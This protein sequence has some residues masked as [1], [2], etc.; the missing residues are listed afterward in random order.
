MAIAPGVI[1]AA[2]DMTIVYDERGRK[3]ELPR[4]VISDPSNLA[5][6]GS[7]KHRTSSGGGAGGQ[8]E[9]P[10][11]AAGAGGGSGGSGGSPGGG[12]PEVAPPSQVAVR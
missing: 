9:L 8:L 12:L 10:A 1:V 6:D 7:A 4:Y 3:Y 5:R 2:P 11:V